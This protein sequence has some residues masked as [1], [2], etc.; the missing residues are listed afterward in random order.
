MYPV[1]LS[2]GAL[3][4]TS[5]SLLLNLGLAAGAAITLVRAQ[6][7]GAST[8]TTIDV[9][10]AALVFGLLGARVAYAAIHWAYYRDHLDEVWRVWLGGLSWPGGLIGG[11]AGVWLIGRMRLK[12]SAAG[13]LDVLAPGLAAGFIF[14]WIGC[15]LSA[16]A[17][18][19]EVFPGQTLFGIALDAP[20]VY[21]SWA[22]RLPSQLFG[23]AWAVCV[24]LAIAYLDRRP[25]RRAGRLFALFVVLYSAGSFAIG[26][27]RADAAAWLGDWSVDQALDL[28]LFAAGVGAV[29]M[30]SRRADTSLAV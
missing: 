29:W 2:S 3:T 8:A 6:R 21:G 25:T 1:V 15:F 24:L 16:C 22:P 28:A 20:D 17:Y 18:G 30:T 13:W 23:A 12:Q 7:R 27:S 19:R 10:L 4:L 9:L 26:F 5:Y 11:L 14:G